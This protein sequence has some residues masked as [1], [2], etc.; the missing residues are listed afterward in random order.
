MA[1]N[2]GLLVDVEVEPTS[3]E[4]VEVLNNGLKSVTLAGGEANS[5]TKNMF[6]GVDSIQ[7]YQNAS[8][9]EI[10]EIKGAGRQRMNSVTSNHSIR[11]YESTGVESAT[12]GE[13][14]LPDVGYGGRLTPKSKKTRGRENTPLIGGRGRH[15]SEYEDL[16]D[17][18]FN[19]WPN[20]PTFNDL[21][22]EAETAVDQGVYPTRIYQG[23]SGSYF[24]KNVEGKTIGVFK[25]KDE[26]PYG[27]LN[28]KWTKWM[29]RMC[30]PC[31]FGRSCLIPNQGY[32][33]EAG[34]SL[35]DQKLG[36]NVVPN[37]KV[38]K[39]SSET[40]NYLRI[41]VEKSKAKKAVNEH[42]P[43]VGRKF[44]R[45][46]L[47]PK[48]GSFQV[49]VENFK[50]ADFHL[51][52]FESDPLDPD[53]SK[54]FQL[55]FEKL[56]VLD[57]IIR[58]TDRGNDNWLINYKKAM[59]ASENEEEGTPASIQVAAIDNGLAFPIKHPDSWRAYPYHWAWLPYAKIPFSQ[60]TRDLVLEKI[61]DMNF[62]Q[63]IC[64][65][66]HELF[67]TDKGF[68]RQMFEKQMSVMRGQILNLS[69]ALKDGK[70]PLQLV[71]MPSVFVERSRG[72]VGTTEKFRNF[73]NTF[74]QRF[75][76]KAPFFSWC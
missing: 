36:L 8:D 15:R 61:S 69:Q 30:C 9:A 1:Q 67:M 49:F 66:M 58:N 40:F 60:E 68:D 21:I 5:N 4:G 57:Y 16:D 19:N 76:K 70:S 24:V 50:D 6:E 11:S 27:R 35:V 41:D 39:L 28:P 14:L 44:N 75:Q 31:C 46:G 62:V 59:A 55:Q 64:D 45:L 20:D 56:V 7:T 51:R 65:E 37:T 43:K 33:S 22:K 23:S 53:T 2:G 25:P 34:A 12:S 3:S 26:E 17:E 10:G 74:T 73:S 52:K 71:Q 32:M 29:H 72:H 63:D 54:D 48:K 18:M 42:F 13:A 47:P 38:V